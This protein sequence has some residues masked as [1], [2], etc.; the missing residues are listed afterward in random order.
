MVCLFWLK[1]QSF[2]CLLSDANHQTCR[3]SR[4]QATEPLPALDSSQH[5]RYSIN[6]GTDLHRLGVTEP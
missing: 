5:G 4:A 3:L 6:R 1:M 2:R